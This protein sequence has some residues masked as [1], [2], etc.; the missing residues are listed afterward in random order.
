[1]YLG[2]SHPTLVNLIFGLPVMFLLLMLTFLNARPILKAPF[3]ET[4]SYKLEFYSF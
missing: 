4:N 2:E 3:H 1:M